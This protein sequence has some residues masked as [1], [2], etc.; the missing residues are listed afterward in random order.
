MQIEE[1]TLDISP[2]GLKELEPLLA[3]ERRAST[4]S[5]AAT[6]LRR[7]TVIA[8]KE[9]IPLNILPSSV[10]SESFHDAA[11][12]L[13]E[14][15]LLDSSFHES[16]FRTPISQLST[17]S[18]HSN[19]ASSS[20]SLRDKARI[21]QFGFTVESQDVTTSKKL[22][23][24]VKETPISQ[25]SKY[26]QLP[27][28]MRMTENSSTAQFQVNKYI[29]TTAVHDGDVFVQANAPQSAVVQDRKGDSSESFEHIEASDAN[30]SEDDTQK[31]DSSYD[32]L[33]SDHSEH[34]M[35]EIRMLSSSDA[36]IVKQNE[37][38]DLL[39]N[40]PAENTKVSTS[41]VT[42]DKDE[43]GDSTIIQQYQVNVTKSDI[44]KNIIVLSSHEN[45][46]RKT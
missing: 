45:S 1:A 5:S 26:A 27:A 41:A 30:F 20:S 38:L 40:D 3:E 21:S 4:S 22:D 33:G 17:D 19:E 24:D 12:E 31:S 42:S 10:G 39:P 25:K 32:L 14:F 34:A 28:A 18:G 36:V 44:C 35:A 37:E 43:P 9:T 16:E 7:R 11:D 6:G 46:H 13:P 2:R 29:G 15:P 23:V 8:T